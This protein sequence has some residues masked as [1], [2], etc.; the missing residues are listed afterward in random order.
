MF[1]KIFCLLVKTYEDQDETTKGQ[2]YCYV[3]DFGEQMV[4]KSQSVIVILD[5][6]TDEIKVVP[7]KKNISST[8]TQVNFQ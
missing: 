3:E 8:G 7:R 5:L 4:G 6:E 1:R 2:E